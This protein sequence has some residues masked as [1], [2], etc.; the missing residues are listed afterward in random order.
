MRLFAL[1]VLLAAKVLLII[2]QPMNTNIWPKLRIWRL[3]GQSN[4]MSM[5]FECHCLIDLLAIPA[6]QILSVLDRAGC[7]S[8]NAS[9]ATGK[10]EDCTSSGSHQK[11]N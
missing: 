5:A 4:I 7:G 11:N 8:P 6:A 10:N 2:G 1:F 3:N 9:N